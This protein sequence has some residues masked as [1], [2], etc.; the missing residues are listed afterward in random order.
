MY[1]VPAG[2]L[3]NSRGWRVF[4]PPLAPDS[5]ESSAS[6]MA[7]EEA[8]QTIHSRALSGVCQAK[9]G[10]SCQ[11]RGAD[12]VIAY[13]TCSQTCASGSNPEREV[14]GGKLVSRSESEPIRPR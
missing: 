1:F 8:A 5:E 10:S 7:V 2:T 13:S 4:E 6:A 11:L 12:H 14:W 3:E 9:P